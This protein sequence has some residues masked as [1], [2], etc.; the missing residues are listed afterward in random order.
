M[1]WLSKGGPKEVGPKRLA[2]SVVPDRGQPRMNI[3]F[4]PSIKRLVER[5]VCGSCS[6]LSQQWFDFIY[7]KDSVLLLEDKKKCND[8]NR[9]CDKEAIN[10]KG[11]I[12]LYQNP[13][14]GI[15]DYRK[16]QN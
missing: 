11:K 2:R 3:G 5:V 1:K 10:G 13:H 16:D 14:L 6:G 4:F 12:A 8:G 9:G 7:N 15:C